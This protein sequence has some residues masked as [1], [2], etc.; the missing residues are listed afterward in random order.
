M[1]N[2]L[3][4]L[5][6]AVGA[7]VASLFGGF[8]AGLKTLLICMAIDYVSGLVVAGVFKNSP[9]TDGGALQ[10]AACL[11]GL[12]RKIMM[13]CLVVLAYQMDIIIGSDYIRDLV[14]IAFIANEAISILE[15]AGLMGIK[16]PKALTK[17]ID[18][19][20]EKADDTEEGETDGK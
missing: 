1:K 12:I 13:L 20:K 19:L 16:L 14:I 3:C 4:T 17:A 6:G 5:L 15:N 8:D 9:K 18:I 11:K 7:A 2:T 10:S